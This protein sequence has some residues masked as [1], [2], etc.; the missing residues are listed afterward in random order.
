MFFGFESK[1]ST[2]LISTD[3][4]NIYFLFSLFDI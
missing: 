2:F 1:I 4:L 3:A